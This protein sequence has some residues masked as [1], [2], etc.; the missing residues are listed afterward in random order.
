MRKIAGLAVLFVLFIVCS[1]DDTFTYDICVVNSCTWPIR[2]NITTSTTNST[3]IDIPIDGSYTFS[4][5]DNGDYYIYVTSADGSGAPANS[6]N[7]YTNM[8]IFTD[9]TWTI[10]WDST[11]GYIIHYRVV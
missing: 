1:C 5:Y 11:D 7:R 2:V 10:S 4:G 6:T 8:R 9:D 3:W